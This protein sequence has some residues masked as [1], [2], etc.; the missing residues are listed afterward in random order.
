MD[1]EPDEE[2]HLGAFDDVFDDEAAGPATAELAEAAP[3]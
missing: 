3:S 1:D 2:V